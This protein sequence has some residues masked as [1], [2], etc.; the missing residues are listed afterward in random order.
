[1]SG[2]GNPA[3]IVYPF[4]FPWLFIFLWTWV[5]IIYKD[6]VL[7][8]LSMVNKYLL[9]GLSVLVVGLIFGAT[10]MNST[11]KQLENTPYHPFRGEY[12]S[13][14]NIYTNT[15]F[16]NGF[17]FG[18][19]VFSVFVGILLWIKILARTTNERNKNV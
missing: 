16:F 9:F 7:K 17:T 18:V 14:I 10:F 4:L 5:V 2:N 6:F 19:L 11:L 8:S 3:I 13:V 15:I 1:M 12:G